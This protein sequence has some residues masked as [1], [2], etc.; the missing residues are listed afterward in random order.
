MRQSKMKFNN[1]REMRSF[2]ASIKKRNEVAIKKLN[3]DIKEYEN[4]LAK[5]ASVFAEPQVSYKRRMK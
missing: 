2:L 3:S 1:V 4:L 5:T